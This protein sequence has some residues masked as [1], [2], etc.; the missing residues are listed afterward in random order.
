MVEAL[1]ELLPVRA[2]LQVASP[3]CF[4]SFFDS[5]AAASLA[6]A[7]A[8]ALPRR[9][10]ALRE[11]GK[12]GGGQALGGVRTLSATKT[13]PRGPGDDGEGKGSGGLGSVG[14]VCEALSY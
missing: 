2:G 3:N 14:Q 8:A 9:Q 10:Q 6:P 7:A 4:F 1:R 11:G 13:F 5:T 12:G